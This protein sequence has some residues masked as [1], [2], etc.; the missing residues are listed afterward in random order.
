[1]DIKETK[2]AIAAV[3]AVGGFVCKR[4]SD[5]ADLSDLAALAGKLFSD[6]EFRAVLEAGATGY[7]K[8]PSELKELDFKESIELIDAIMVAFKR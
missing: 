3:M 5:G 7:D 6:A 1:M 8:I 2:E 4:L